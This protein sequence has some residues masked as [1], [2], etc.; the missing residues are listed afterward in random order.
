MSLCYHGPWGIGDPLHGYTQ[1]FRNITYFTL[2]S[3]PEVPSLSWH[4]ITVIGITNFF[5]HVES[6]QLRDRKEEIIP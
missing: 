3:N 6:V 1:L 5:L 4:S 2:L